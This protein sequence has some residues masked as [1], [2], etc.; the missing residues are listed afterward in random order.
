MFLQQGPKIFFECHVAMM[1]FLARNRRDHRLAHLA[2]F[3]R[4]RL[5]GSSPGLKPRA[6]S[7][8]PFGVDNLLQIRPKLNA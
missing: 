7:S 1:N 4:E 3:Q 2:P 6:E 5:I 8:C